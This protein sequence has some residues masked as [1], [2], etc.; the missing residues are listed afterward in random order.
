MKIETNKF[1]VSPG[2]YIYAALLVLTVPARWVFGFVTAAWIHELGHL[3]ALKLLNV[4]ILRIHLEVSGAVIETGNIGTIQ[5]L[6]SAAAG[7]AAGAL[8]VFTAKLFPEISF[9]ALAQTVFNLIPVYPSDGGRIL[10][11]I[12]CTLLQEKHATSII[13]WITRFTLAT[14]LAVCVYLFRYKTLGII[15]LL[16][17]V[18]IGRRIV[19]MKN[20]L[21][22]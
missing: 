17:V 15:P 9:C 22:R 16:G 20:S 14:L 2:F 11:C 13:M 7:P 12:L 19:N 5:E 18:L 10:R 6:V 21:Q 3:L 1:N 8:T 4:R